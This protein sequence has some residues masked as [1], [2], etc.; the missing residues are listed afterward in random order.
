M[1]IIQL[2]GCSGGSVY[3]NLERDTLVARNWKPLWLT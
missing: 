2:E 1:Q 3:M